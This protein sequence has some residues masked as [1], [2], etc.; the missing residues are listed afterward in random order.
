MLLKNRNDQEE[1]IGAGTSIIALGTCF[2][3]NININCDVRIDGSIECNVQS[4]SKVV[5]GVDGQVTGDIAGAQVDVMGSVN[6]NIYAT[7]GINLRNRARVQGN[8]NTSSLE[9]ARGALLDGKCQMDGIKD[10]AARVAGKPKIAAVAG[11]KNEPEPAL[12]EN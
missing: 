1:A 5:I 6:G 4:Q 10:L 2:T 3:G 9:G 12:S 8:I 7:D 11:K